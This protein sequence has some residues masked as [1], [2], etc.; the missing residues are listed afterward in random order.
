M[1]DDR[2]NLIPNQIAAALEPYGLVP[3]GGF[4]FDEENAPSPLI[5]GG[6]FRSVVLVGHFGSAIWPHFTRWWQ[7]H[8]DSQDP[9]DQWSKDVLTA[10]AVKFGAIAVFP[11]DRP[12]LPFQQWA[13]R[14]EG[15]RPSPLGILIHP[16]Y[17]LWQAFRGALLF[18]R[19]LDFASGGPQHHPCDDCQDKPCLSACP[20]NAF[21][22]DGYNVVR[23]RS[24]LA[25]GEGNEC[26]KGGCLARRACPVGCEQ[27]YNAPQM[28]FHM[29]AFAKG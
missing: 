22:G 11:S 25:S 5:R 18:D 7:D 15:L 2:E 4:V 16:Q 24:H 3:R 12:Y 1:Q 14:A 20:V 6:H 23:C 29:K 19:A 28:R 9:L 13:M 26:L 8:T 10:V 17:G 21:A 27:A